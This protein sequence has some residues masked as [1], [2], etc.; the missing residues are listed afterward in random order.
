MARDSVIKGRPAQETAP[1]RFPSA[2]AAG[3]LALLVALVVPACGGSSPAEPSAT[4][5]AVVPAPTTPLP[6]MSVMLAE[7]SI[8]SSTAP[9][10]MI[11]YSSLTCSHCGDFHTAT[12]PLL[13]SAYIGAGR[14]RFVFRDYPLN[15]AATAASMVAR[16][17]GDGYFATL[18]ALFS[19]QASW[20]YATDYASGIKKA[21]AG[22]GITSNDVDACLA[23]TELRNGVLAIKQGGTQTYGVNVTPT[24]IINGQKVVG[25][26][27]YAQFAA[28]I[29]AY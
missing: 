27:P 23:S 29:D 20:A 28:I 7:K 22:L 11:E 17:S 2:A 21:V 24:F 25:A 18:D 5:P 1:A 14:V 19:A 26:L 12:L 3:I 10:T 6:S 4:T 9:V 13:K 8:G 16:C 15:D